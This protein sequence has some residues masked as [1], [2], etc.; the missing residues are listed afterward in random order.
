MP[1]LRSLM[2]HDRSP[3]TNTSELTAEQRASEH[4][5]PF[6]ITRYFLCKIY[7]NEHLTPHVI[8][9]LVFQP[10]KNVIKQLVN[11]MAHSI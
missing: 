5:H 4:D 7:M 1:F 9:Q 8:A 3:Y 11:K 2:W 10:R 6:F